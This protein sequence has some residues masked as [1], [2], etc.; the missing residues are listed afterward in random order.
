MHSR[1]RMLVIVATA[2]V[3]ST[4]LALVTSLGILMD[5]LRLPT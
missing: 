1:H 3:R 2:V 4:Q 5:H